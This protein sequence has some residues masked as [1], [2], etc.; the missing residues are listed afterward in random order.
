[1]TRVVL[2]DNDD[3]EGMEII[4]EIQEE[5]STGITMGGGGGEEW[6]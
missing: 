2:E 4:K 1:M 5:I 6:E 3:K